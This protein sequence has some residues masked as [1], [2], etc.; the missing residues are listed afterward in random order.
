MPGPWADRNPSRTA[1]KNARRGRGPTPGLDGEAGGK[2]SLEREPQHVTKLS[3]P[4]NV[5]AALE[6]KAKLWTEKAPQRDTARPR[7]P[8]GANPGAVHSPRVPPYG[9]RR[10]ATFV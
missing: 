3:C 10:S 7:R 4:H 8:P 1:Q 5:A 6:F 2:A 9:R